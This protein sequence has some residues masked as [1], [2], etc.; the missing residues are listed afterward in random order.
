M[1]VEE[2]TSTTG[3]AL[4]PQASNPLNYDDPFNSGKFKGLWIDSS[5][6]SLHYFDGIEDNKLSGG[7]IWEQHMPDSNPNG[8]E[9]RF[10]FQHIWRADRILLYEE[11][12]ELIVGEDVDV[13]SERGL[14]TVIFQSAPPNG[15]RIWARYEKEV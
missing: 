15:S 12:I 13:V 8:S 9:I 3:L 14:K 1:F 6:T 11:G 4:V 10:V 5:D 7:E 2:L